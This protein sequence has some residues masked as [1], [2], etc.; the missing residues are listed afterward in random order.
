MAHSPEASGASPEP[1]PSPAPQIAAKPPADSDGAT[2][3]MPGYHFLNCELKTPLLEAWRARD[4]NNQLRSVKIISGLARRH[5]LSDQDLRRAAHLRYVKHP[6]LMPIES[7]EIEA[8][9]FVIVTP[10]PEFSLRLRHQ[11]AVGMGLPGVPREELLIYLRFIAEGLDFLER[12][13]GLHHLSLSP[14]NMVLMQGM[15]RVADYGLVELAWLPAGQ[16][17]D[18]NSLK[19]SA[20]EIFDNQFTRS[21]DQYSLACIYCEMMTGRLPHH[22]THGKVLREQRLKALHDLSL[23]PPHEI[24]ILVRA[25]APEPAKR[26]QSAVEF[27]RALEAAMPAAQ[28]QGRV[29]YAAAAPGS[30]SSTPMVQTAPHFA[31]METERAVQQLVQLAAYTTI[32]REQG[33]IR[34][35]ID[36]R[37]TLSHRCAAWL[38]AGM[39]QQKLEGFSY[40]WQAQVVSSGDDLLVYRMDLPQKFWRRLVRGGQDYLEIR[41]HISPSRMPES[42]LSEVLIQVEYQGKYPEEGRDAVQQFGPPVVYSLRT[43]LLATAEHRTQERFAFD[44][45]L[46]VYPNYAGQPGDGVCC[47]SKNISR[48]GIGFL[49]PFRLPTRD[50]FVQVMTTELGAISVPATVLRTHPLPEGQYEIGARF[51]LP[52]TVAGPPL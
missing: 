16:P 2:S 27:V 50:I 26:Y 43:C 47:H 34:Y 17:L 13:E 8:G 5:V 4:A 32:V 40:Q 24:D 37:G 38:P 44:C 25:M 30:A 39:A 19:Y 11:E 52:S 14:S 12:Q 41:V 6:R 20:P 3:G 42:K 33:G 29:G 1:T 10:Y 49:S 48:H 51:H 35:H 23:M 36:D 21:S 15:P 28:N 7:I 46:W 31:A 9:R 45:P 18:P 22:A